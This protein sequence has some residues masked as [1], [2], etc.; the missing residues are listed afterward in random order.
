MRLIKEKIKFIPNQSQ[1]IQ[2]PFSE[3]VD[4]LGIEDD[5]ND[6][7]AEE[8]GLSINEVDDAETFRYLPE[9]LTNSLDVYFIDGGSY[10]DTPTY[11]AAGFTSDEISSRD[12]VILRSFYLIQVYDSTV[13]QNQ[14]LLSTGY[15]NGFNFLRENDSSTL[16]NYNSDDEFSNIYIPQWFI[17]AISGVTTIYGKLSFYNAKKGEL[18]LFSHSNSSGSYVQPTT[19]DDGYFEINLNPDN[20]SYTVDTI[21]GFELGNA[22]Y[23][24][25]INKSLDSFDNEKPTYPSGNTFLNTGKYVINV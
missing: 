2:I 3:N 24:E 4:F 13:A 23:V 21:Y 5:I 14:T 1:N 19:D 15:Y 20:Y 6:F 16:Y 22:D 18:Q 8:T 11:E 12:E 7:I 25:K 9:N 17:E 10:G